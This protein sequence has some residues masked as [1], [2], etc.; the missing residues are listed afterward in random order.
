MS[1]TDYIPKNYREGAIAVSDLLP[2]LDEIVISAHVN[3]DGDAL[4]SLSAC[5]YI[6]EKLNRKFFIYSATPIP[7][8]LDFLNLPKKIY[9][10]LYQ[11]PFTPKAAIYLDCSEYSRLGCELANLS[12]PSINIDHHLSEHG[13]GTMYNY[14]DPHAS[15]TCQLMA[16]VGLACDISLKDNLAVSLALGLLTDTGGFAHTNTTAQVFSLCA[17]L[18]KNGC[19][20]SQLNDNL[21]SR[22]TLNRMRL[23]GKLFSEIDIELDGKVALSAISLEDFSNFHCSAEDTEGLVDKLRRIKGVKISAIIR[24]ESSEHCKFSLR[25]VKEVDVQSIAAKFGGG[26]HKNAAGGEIEAS[27]YVSRNL[28]LSAMREYLRIR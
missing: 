6:L 19:D 2:K 24:Q 18:A 20:F 7:Q 16:Y 28:L 4:G 25:S 3:L 17:L 5:G 15:A 9:N 26:G 10:H 11:A 27:L 1:L 14:I 13:M 22:L 21:Q 8:Y 23:W 12:I